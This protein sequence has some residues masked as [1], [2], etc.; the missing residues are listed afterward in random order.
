MKTL[1]QLRAEHE[2]QIAALQAE[3]AIAESIA[4]AGMPVPDYVGGKLWGAVNITYRNRTATSKDE[5]ASIGSGR[6]S[7]SQAIDLFEKFAEV[8]PFNVLSDGGCTT[9]APQKM[10][11]PKDAAKYTKRHMYSPGDY[12][13]QLQVKHSAESHCGANTKAELEFFAMVGGR[14]YCV[15]IEFGTGYIGSC[16][17]LSPITRTARGYRDRVESR[18][19][20]PRAEVSAQH[21]GMISYGHGGDM[22]PVKTGADH[23]HLF[24]A[25]CHDDNLSAME[26]EH[27]RECLRTIAEQTGA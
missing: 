13:V 19:Y 24:V 7:M 4:A 11:P 6:R 27:A 5:G 10:L 26:C 25:E 18:S 14:L 15:S 23:R 20:E 2:K 22:G 16:P 21:D 3:S 8:V 1:E 9:M 12:A 17:Q